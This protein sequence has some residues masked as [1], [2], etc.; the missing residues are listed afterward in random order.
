MNTENDGMEN[1]KGISFQICFFVGYRTFRISKKIPSILPVQ[2]GAACKNPSPISLSN[3]N[4]KTTAKND[5]FLL[6]QKFIQKV[7]DGLFDDGLFWIIG[8]K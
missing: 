2:L 5:G 8:K 3:K 6:D 7:H 1:G 4:K